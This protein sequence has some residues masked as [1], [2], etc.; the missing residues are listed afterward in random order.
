MIGYLHPNVAMDGIGRRMFETLIL[1]IIRIASIHM[2]RMNPMSLP[3]SL[4]IS[5]HG[6]RGALM[7][8][9]TLKVYADNVITKNIISMVRRE[10]AKKVLLR[11]AKPEWV[12]SAKICP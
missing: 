5:C 10:G 2:A 11:E 9:A 7:I 12:T 3:R 1:Q 8:G 4:T 6:D